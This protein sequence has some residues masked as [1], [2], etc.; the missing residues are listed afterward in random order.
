M[1]DLIHEAL[2][3]PKGSVTRKLIASIAAIGVTVGVFAGYAY[4]RQRHAATV[5]KPTPVEKSN[6]AQPQGSPKVLVLVDEAMLRGKS[7]IVGGKVKNISAGPL[8]NLRVELELKRRKD[9]ATETKLVGVDPA[10]LEPSQE[11]LYSLELNG[12]DYGSARLIGLTAGAEASYIAYTT[13]AGQKRPQERP[14]SRTIIVERPRSKGGEFLN[15]PD[16]PAR[17]P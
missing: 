15:T 6:P 17:V 4:I 2:A 11:G 10:E 13:G 12:G 16:N 8:A 1:P 5:V 7:T 14:E 9:G 3:E